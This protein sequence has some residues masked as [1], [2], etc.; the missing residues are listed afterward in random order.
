VVYK[1]QHKITGESHE[2]E[3]PM[4]NYEPYKGPNGNDDQWER[5]YEAPQ[6]NMGVSTAKAIDA[7][8]SKSFVERTGK[9]KGTIGDLENHAAELSAKRAKESLTGEDPLKRKYLNDYSQKRGGKKHVADLKKT[10]E[11]KHIKVEL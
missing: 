1:F 5:I 6:I 4:K 11:N 3:M 7:W 8:D 10:V 9:M 2:V